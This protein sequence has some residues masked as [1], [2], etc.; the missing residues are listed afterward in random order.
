MVLIT[1][2]LY[3]LFVIKIFIYY[4]KIQLIPNILS[5]DA[6]HQTHGTEVREE[7]LSRYDL[8]EKIPSYFPE[9]LD[10]GKPTDALTVVD[11]HY[12]VWSNASMVR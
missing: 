12:Q 6:L 3:G 9:D 4:F 7:Q 2:Y 8:R 5:Q 11:C 1:I 10:F